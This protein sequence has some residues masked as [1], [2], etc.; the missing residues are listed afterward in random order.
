MG[1]APLSVRSIACAVLSDVK[2]PQLLP[3]MMIA[4]LSD[5]AH[6]RYKKVAVF[7][8]YLKVATDLNKWKGFPFFMKTHIIRKAKGNKRL[9]EKLRDMR[10]L[11][12]DAQGGLWSAAEHGDPVFPDLVVQSYDPKAHAIEGV[13]TFE[14]AGYVTSS[15]IDEEKIYVGTRGGVVVAFE[16]ATKQD[17][18]LA[19]Q[20][21]NA[22]DALVAFGGSVYFSVN[23][24]GLV[25][26]DRSLQVLHESRKD[27]NATALAH[28]DKHLFA[29]YFSNGNDPLLGDGPAGGKF[30][31]L[32]DRLR[33]LSRYEGSIPYA[34]S[35][36]T[37]QDGALF[38][39][40]ANM[41]NGWHPEGSG[42]YHILSSMRAKM[43]ELVFDTQSAVTA[44]HVGD[45]V[46]L[47]TKLG[48]V[49]A[50]DTGAKGPCSYHKHKITGL[51]QVENSLYV[52]QP[53][54]R[55]DEVVLE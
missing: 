36:A 7:R 34:V 38:F 50:G 25:H 26:A 22:I 43:P 13:W 48:Q 52:G 41:S 53:D 39:A 10:L 40:T 15:Y 46:H 12:A 27:Q 18:A 30:E 51:A 23:G 20:Q 29:F 44:M 8:D 6:K 35:H 42:A 47:G 54:G 55:I 2:I 45:T 3:S 17:P 28:D 5:R 32:N 37:M 16:A 21:D 4:A 9:P 31:C 33:C 14:E 24:Q 49:F 1:V 19:V 11:G